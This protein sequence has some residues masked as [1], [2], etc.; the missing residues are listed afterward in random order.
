MPDD[1]SNFH[2]EH[3][4]IN[5]SGGFQASEDIDDNFIFRHIKPNIL[6]VDVK[7]HDKKV[8]KNIDKSDIDIINNK[9]AE[10]ISKK[11]SGDAYK[12]KSDSNV[13]FV[14]SCRPKV[15]NCYT[16]LVYS[17]IIC[18]FISVRCR[19]AILNSSTS[20]LIL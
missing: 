1:F 6:N 8:F 17:I 12:S 19:I 11:D 5:I 14:S 7:D 9:Y 16:F 10:N 15:L 18:I 20:T 3:N 13:E 4:H 2:V